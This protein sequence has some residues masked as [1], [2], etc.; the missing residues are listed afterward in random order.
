MEDK[1]TVA[2]DQVLL[3][4]LG[5]N[6]RN[7]A[8]GTVYVFAMTGAGVVTPTGGKAPY[9]ITERPAFNLMNN[10]SLNFNPQVRPCVWARDDSAF[11]LCRR[12]TASATKCRM[13]QQ[14]PCSWKHG[15]PAGMATHRVPA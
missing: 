8:D 13:L 12:C 11:P 6:D 15:L 3:A 9:S 5:A 2:A 1:L 7:L 10:G 4:V 14:A